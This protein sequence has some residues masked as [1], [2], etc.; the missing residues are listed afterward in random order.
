MFLT[1]KLF[2]AISKE[3]PFV[4]RLIF[5]FL[6]SAIAKLLLSAVI[7]NKQINMTDKSG[8]GTFVTEDHEMGSSGLDLFTLPPIDKSQVD[9][10]NKEYL[11]QANITNEGPYEFI[12]PNDSYEYIPMSEIYL[13]GTF[14]I[15]KAD[16]TD[17]ADD[18]KD[19]FTLCNNFPQTLFQQVEV[20]INGQVVNDLSTSNYPYKSFIENHLSYD[21]DLKRTALW[22]REMYIED[23]IGHETNLATGLAQAGKGFRKRRDKAFNKDVQFIMKLHIDFLQVMRYLP[24]GVELKIKLIRSQDHFGI[25]TAAPHVFKVN[26]KQLKIL[27]RKIT[28]DPAVASALMSMNTKKPFVYPVAHSKVRT[29]TIHKDL[30]TV[31]L[32]QVVRGRLPRSFLFTL[33]PASATDANSAINPFHFR[34]FDLN[35]LQVFIDGIPIHPLALQPNWEDDGPL[36]Q[37]H[38]FLNNIG[39]HQTQ[40]NDIT[41]EMFKSNSV[42]FPYDMSPDLCNGVH[43]TGAKNGIVDIHLGFKTALTENVTLMFYGVYDETVLIDGNKAVTIV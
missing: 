11:L 22:A 12:I 32:S 29:F 38:W 8:L 17:L 21:H 3:Q 19:K 23:P 25:I 15:I 43:S 1:V 10:T 26:I 34:H 9:G 41:F 33:L 4:L 30:K 39:L 36:E 40:S 14:R 31:Q 24:P 5:T 35:Y 16:G 20:S 2:L 13:K 27:M 42:F 18:D 6:T 7:K 37:Y 28:L